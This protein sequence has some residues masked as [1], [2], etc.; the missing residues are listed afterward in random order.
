MLEN[1]DEFDDEIVT[2]EHS[3]REI[4]IMCYFAIT[5]SFALISTF[6]TLSC[7]VVSNSSMEIVSAMNVS[8]HLLLC[9]ICIAISMYSLKIHVPHIQHDH[10]D[11]DAMWFDDKRFSSV[12]IVLFMVI[13][14]TLNIIDHIHHGHRVWTDLFMYLALISASMI[15]FSECRMRSDNIIRPMFFMISCFLIL[16]FAVFITPGRPS[17]IE[18][19][20]MFISILPFLIGISME[21]SITI[22]QVMIDAS[23]FIFQLIPLIAHGKIDDMESCKYDT[24]TMMYS[25]GI[26]F[27]CLGA[28][29]RVFRKL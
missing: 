3:L 23:G 20:G 26:T 17:F 14:L 9:F 25:V 7:S 1:M 8:T 21:H 19:F 18:Y 6:V 28:M 15:G 27:A 24:S 16:S 22:E 13:S 5:A 11:T 4:R 2:K 10:S 12:M 29:A